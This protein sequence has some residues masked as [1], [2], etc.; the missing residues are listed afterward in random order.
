[1]MKM[2]VLRAE[3]TLSGFSTLKQQI[4]NYFY[5][6]STCNGENGIPGID[7][8]PLVGLVQDYLSLVACPALSRKHTRVWSFAQL[9][10]QVYSPHGKCPM[11]SQ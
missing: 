4:H 5:D 10:R 7:T 11:A 8:A 6:S 3:T 1:M 2:K 9:L